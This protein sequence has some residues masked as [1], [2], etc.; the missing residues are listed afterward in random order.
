MVSTEM[1]EQVASKRNDAESVPV[2]Q[3]VLRPQRNR[4]RVW[5]GVGGVT[6]ALLVGGAAGWSGA[7][8]FAPPEQVLESDAF[9][10]VAVT[11]GEVGSSI[12]L[13]AVASW[14][15]SPVALNG[16]SGTVTSVDIEPG[17]VVEVG[18]R[19]YSVE[20]RPVVAGQGSIPAYGQIA[21]GDRGAQVAQ[22]QQ[23][24][25]DLGYWTGDTRGRYTAGFAVAVRNWQE[26]A[27]YPVDAVVQG[28]DIVWVPQLPARM[29][30]DAEVIEKGLIVTAG[31]GGITALGETPGFQIP[32]QSSQTRFAPS[33]T[34]VIVQAP[35]GSQW[36]ALAGTQTPDPMSSET[37]WVELTAPDGGPVCGDACDL[38]AAEGQ[39]TLLSE[40][41]TVPVESGLVVP[42]SAVTTDA[43]GRAFVV[44]AEGASHEV[45]VGQSARGMVLVE[46][47]EEGLQV[48][49]PVV[50][51]G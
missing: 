44:D 41:I 51:E 15:T 26:A 39:V 7:T 29:S 1:T 30:L 8:V 19:L 4:G 24:L 11:Q 42:A 49:V 18:Q 27:G 38:I 22:L 20:L 46:G 13:N 48:R 47:V 21:P 43:S 32:M 12:S 37:I 14:S 40:I 10:T 9:S 31:T 36:E 3:R 50:Q 6:I 45:T 2:E 5:R 16:A 34:R 17:A 35:D 33:G 25:I 23:F 28:G